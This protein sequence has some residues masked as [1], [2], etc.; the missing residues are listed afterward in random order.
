M[1][2]LTRLFG[3]G[4]DAC[5]SSTG[6]EQETN[7]CVHCGT[8]VACADV[9]FDIGE[10][11]V[12]GIVGESGSGKSTVAGCLAFDVPASAGEARLCTLPGANMFELDAAARRRLRAMEIGIVYQ[13]PQ[14]GLR[15]DVTAGGNVAERL[16]SADW[17]HVGQI[18]ERAGNLLERTE[19]PRARMDEPPRIFSGGMRQRVQLAKALAHKP[20]LLI[21]DE[22][23]TGLDVSVQARILDLIQEI[24]REAG[25]ATIVISHDL[26]VIR[27]LTERTLVMRLGRVVEAGLTDQILDDPQH[28][29]TQLLVNSA[30]T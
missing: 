7:R 24:Q 16:L 25:V 9:S 6:P 2:G 26:G 17:R 12:L 10:G 5:L 8:T 27:L 11:E 30:L 15:L 28:P 22:P 21:L 13:T 1:S 4:C 14:Q 29:Y 19:I 18:R 3:P 23:T 20:S